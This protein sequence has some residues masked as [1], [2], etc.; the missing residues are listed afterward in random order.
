M[1][2]TSTPTEFMH[3][4]FLGE[5][6]CYAQYLCTNDICHA[7]GEA[8]HVVQG[9]L[10]VG[11]MFA[12]RRRNDNPLKKFEAWLDAVWWPGDAGRVPKGVRCYKLR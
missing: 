12:K 3:A 5:C 2:V 11:G 9:I 4:G 1:P 7:I 6:S 8:K 10:T